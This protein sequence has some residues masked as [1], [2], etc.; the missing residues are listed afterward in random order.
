MAVARERL[1][2]AE[3]LY[4]T[5]DY[6]H[7][8]TELRSAFTAIAECYLVKEIDRSFCAGSSKTCFDLLLLQ[9]LRTAPQFVMHP[10]DE[11]PR[12]SEAQSPQDLKG[13]KSIAIKFVVATEFFE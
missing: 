11:C 4:R 8:L 6:P 7:V 9:Q 13:L 3:Q 12:F 10:H 5:G 1:G 2:R